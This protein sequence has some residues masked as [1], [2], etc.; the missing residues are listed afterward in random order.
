MKHCSRRNWRDWETCIQYT[1]SSDRTIQK[2]VYNRQADDGN[3]NPV[4]KKNKKTANFQFMRERWSSAPGWC[5]DPKFK[6]NYSQ[7]SLPLTGLESI[8]WLVLGC[9]GDTYCCITHNSSKYSQWCNQALFSSPAKD[10][11]GVR[12]E[13]WGPWCYYRSVRVTGPEI[14]SWSLPQSTL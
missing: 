4:I 14:S 5:W 12:S 1:L 2:L 3:A 9:K 11:R 10:G 7:F 8:A 13:E 6:C